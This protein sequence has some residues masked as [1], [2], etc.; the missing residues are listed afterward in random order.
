MSTRKDFLSRPSIARLPPAER[1][2]RWRQHVS[3]TGRQR[4]G[5]TQ[6]RAPRLRAQPSPIPA[7]V[8]AYKKMILDPFSN[9][10]VK[11][12]AY[13]GKP[14][15]LVSAKTSFILQPTAGGYAGFS[16]RAVPGSNQSGVVYSTSTNVAVNAGT[17]P[18]WGD[19][20]VT[21]PNQTG[22]PYSTTDLL[23]GQKIDFRH[24]AFA[25]RYR[26]LGSPLNATGRALTTI[27]TT[28]VDVAN[29]AIISQ[30]GFRNF[31]SQPL[32]QLSDWVT[33]PALPMASG[34]T[35]NSAQTPF[36]SWV[37]YG[38][39]DFTS[40]IGVLFTGLNTSGT[41]TI[42]VEVMQVTEYCGQV[43]Y[44]SSTPTPSFHD[45]TMNMLSVL[46]DSMIGSM[47][48][49]IIPERNAVSNGFQE[50]FLPFLGALGGAHMARRNNQANQLRLTLA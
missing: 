17:L 10:I 47:G 7:A 5:T 9:P 43:A 18:N 15:Q 1:E 29:T 49:G 36:M 6:P 24:T 3:S 31:R 33:L 21:E 30:S 39:T 45:A 32:Q 28:D 8:L 37:R 42:E 20:N 14:S 12:P 38:G 23:D 13:G 46:Y 2:R 50:L 48:P 22:L 44:N 34:L 27:N 35:T 41:S 26:Y 25:A 4:G 16:A 40:P 11:C 19:A